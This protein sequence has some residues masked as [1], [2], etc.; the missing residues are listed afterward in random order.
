MVYE[1]LQPIRAFGGKSGGWSMTQLIT[2]NHGEKWKSERLCS[3][4][5]ILPFYPVWDFSLWKGA[6]HIPFSANLSGNTLT[7]ISQECGEHFTQWVTIRS[8]VDKED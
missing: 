6:T 5:P 4:C 3:S 8:E 2:L 1:G 7:D